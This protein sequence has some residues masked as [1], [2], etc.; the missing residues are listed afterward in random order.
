MIWSVIIIFFV[1]PSCILYE[2]R[3]FRYLSGLIELMKLREFL[4]AQ[5]VDY[6]LPIQI[7]L[8]IIFC[9]LKS[10]IDY[11][12]HIDR[13][14]PERPIYNSLFENYKRCNIS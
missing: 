5:L 3:T 10:S 4:Y 11:E 14:D 8:K 13:Y 1:Y 9:F 6:P 7:R 12:N 2:S